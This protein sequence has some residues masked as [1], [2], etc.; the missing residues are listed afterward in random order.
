MLVSETP[1]SQQE[2]KDK[3]KVLSEQ[4]NFT[5]GKFESL[6]VTPYIIVCGK[7]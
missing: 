4:T 6:P 3:M 2:R 1:E 7:Y 5:L